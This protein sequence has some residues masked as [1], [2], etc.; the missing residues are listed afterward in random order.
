[1]LIHSVRALLAILTF[2]LVAGCGIGGSGGGKKPPIAGTGSLTVAVGGLPLGVSPLIRVTGPRDY[3]QNV[4][5]SQTLSALTAGSYTVTA[6]PVVT[7]G[8]SYSATSATQTVTVANDATANVTVT[9][10]ASQFSLALQDVATVSG[11]VF[12]TSP[13][14]DNR[15]F[16]VDRGG[17]IRVVQNGALLPTPFLDISSRVATTGEGGLLS[18]AFHPQYASNG[19][20]F[21]YYTDAANNIIVE[22]RHAAGSANVAD[23]TP[24]LEIIRIAHPNFSNHFGGLVSFGP[25]NLLYLGTGDGGGAGDPQGNAQNLNSLLGKM[26]RIDVNNPGSGLPYSIPATNP[27]AGQSGRRGEIFAPGLRNPWRFAF[28]SNTLYI[29]DVGQNLREEVNAV[30][31]TQNNLNFGWNAMEGSACFM[32]GCSQ[33][34]LTLPIFEYEHGANNV[35]GCSIT[36]G[37]VYRGK[38]IP[39]LAG[40]YFYSDYCEGYL[41]SFLYN[42]GAV[43]EKVS[44][45]IPDIGDV[46][47]FGRDADGELYM[48][49]A[50]GRVYRIR[51]ATT[52]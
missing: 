17:R 31:V 37:F 50:N 14:G 42:G 9:Y 4:T 36:G 33:T 21:I 1:M 44:W 39:E 34:G 46:V 22:R 23:S 28:D 47:S 18:M 15:Q 30:T 45:T 32:A 49:N 16:I 19:Y 48:I 40:R 25:D 51:K 43:S 6:S 5:S 29:A 10:S 24:A 27:Y 12:L 38:A 13:P 52:G 20:F 2:G 3:A 7:G 26:L 8:T 41:K 11:A 35:N